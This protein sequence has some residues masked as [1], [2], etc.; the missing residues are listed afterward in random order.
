MPVILSDPKMRMRSVF[1]RQR[2]NSGRA[3]VA[4]TTGPAAQLVVDT[5]GFM[6][7]GADH[8]QP[9]RIDHLL[10][11][12]LP[13]HFGGLAFGFI[14]A[15]LLQF[16]FEVAAEYDI[17]AA[18]RHVGGYGDR[19]GAARLRDDLGLTLMLL[20]VE[21]LVLEVIFLHL[22]RQELRGLDGRRTKQYRL[23]FLI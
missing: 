18:A 16:L 10:M 2:K 6:A 12:L 7:F 19:P 14:V 1:E 4:L 11:P 20:G 15:D 5:P 17:G 21:H 8:V 23:A 9:A 3:R 13:G 22:C